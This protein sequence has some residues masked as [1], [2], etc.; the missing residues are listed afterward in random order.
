MII[1]QLVVGY[2]SNVVVLSLRNDLRKQDLTRGVEEDEIAPRGQLSIGH[3]TDGIGVPAIAP[4]GKDIWL[5]SSS[6]HIPY[7]AGFPRL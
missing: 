5:I 6:S 3:D 7:F 2:K 1:L 4:E